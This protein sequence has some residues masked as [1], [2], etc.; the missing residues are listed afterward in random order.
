MTFCQSKGDIPYFETSA[1]EAINVEQAFEGK[2]PTG[3][4]SVNHANIHS[5]SYCTKC[6]C[7]GGIRGI[8]RRLLR[9]DQ[10]PHR[11]RPWR[12]CLLI[13]PNFL[14]SGIPFAFIFAT[15]SSTA[16]IRAMYIIGCWPVLGEFVLRC[17]TQDFLWIKWS[18]SGSAFLVHSELV[19]DLACELDIYL[20]GT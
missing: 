19:I 4:D 6:S 11:K 5:H 16:L 13:S 9:P 10:Y 1:K 18:I 15:A 14:F 17:Y 2:N 12:M 20:F 8:Q 7:A 3:K